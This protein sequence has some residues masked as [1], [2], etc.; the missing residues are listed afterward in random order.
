MIVK[1]GNYSDALPGGLGKEL[2]D[3]PCGGIL[4][5][6]EPRGY[7]YVPHARPSLVDKLLG[8]RSQTQERICVTPIPGGREDKASGAEARTRLL[9]GALAACRVLNLE[10][11]ARCT[12]SHCVKIS[13]P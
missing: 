2:V 3:Q 9:C 7:S 4:Y 10:P 11:E 13:G 6:R 1:N 12:E 5:S 8:E